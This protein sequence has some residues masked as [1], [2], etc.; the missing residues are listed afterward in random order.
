MGGKASRDKGSRGERQLRDELTKQ[1]WLG[2]MRIPLSG[3]MK[4]F[5]G[6]VLARH[7]ARGTETNFE[8]KL[9]AG[10]PFKALYAALESR[11][12]SLGPV[13]LSVPDFGEFIMS[14]NAADVMG[15]N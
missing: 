15:Y 2:A 9:R 14:F 8:C 4:G 12:E 7:P 3:A 11:P 5:K 13:C 6:D 1:G 10:L